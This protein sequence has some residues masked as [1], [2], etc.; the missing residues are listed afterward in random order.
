[1][2]AKGRSRYTRRPASIAPR[3]Y[4]VVFTEGTKTEPEYLQSLKAAQ[5]VSFD[6]DGCGAVPRT[7]VDKAIKRLSENGPAA[8]KG[9]E[10]KIDV[11]WC[12][13]DTE[14]VG[15]IDDLKNIINRANAKGI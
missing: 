13:F 8:R 3:Q 14:R 4:V 15:N 11:V 2:R 9:R 1:M 12:A 6:V 7:I 5:R 10:A